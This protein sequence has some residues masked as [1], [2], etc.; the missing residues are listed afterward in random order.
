M[1]GCQKPCG[2]GRGGVSE[3]AHSRVLKAAKRLKINRVINEPVGR[4]LH[5]PI[6]MQS[7]N[8]TFYEELGRR[9]ATA[10]RAIRRAAC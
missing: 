1:E 3:R 2:N 6:L 8:F 4:W 9:L 7:P 10:A 5:V